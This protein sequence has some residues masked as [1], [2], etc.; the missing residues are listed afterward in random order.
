MNEW[1]NKGMNVWMNE[2]M[3]EWMNIRYNIDVKKILQHKMT[4][5]SL[6]ISLLDQITSKI[7]ITAVVLL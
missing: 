7:K 2:W 6:A 5:D 1:M 4:A 3:N